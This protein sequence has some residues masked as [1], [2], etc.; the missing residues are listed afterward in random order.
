MIFWRFCLKVSGVL[1]QTG[2]RW[3]QHS[4]Y[5]QREKVIQVWN[6]TSVLQL[7]LLVDIKIAA[8]LS[9]SSINPTASTPSV[10][11]VKSCQVTGNTSQSINFKQI[12]L[13]TSFII[14]LTSPINANPSSSYL[15]GQIK[16]EMSSVSRTPGFL[17]TGVE[18]NPLRSHCLSP[19]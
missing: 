14:D 7:V 2:L 18:L 3:Q 11:Y 1:S 13:S 15:S 8:I 19:H 16:P 6:N 4:L 10:F 17:R 5:G 9:P 12:I